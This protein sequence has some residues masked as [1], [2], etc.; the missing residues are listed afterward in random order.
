MIV[1]ELE[2]RET[3]KTNSPHFRYFLKHN[4]TKNINK[5]WINSIKPSSSSSSSNFVVFTMVGVVFVCVNKT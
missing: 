5:N 3:E 1:V 4:E 2:F